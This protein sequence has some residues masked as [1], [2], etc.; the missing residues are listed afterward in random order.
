[1]SPGKVLNYDKLV[2]ATDSIPEEPGFITGYS[3]SGV[4]YIHKSFPKMK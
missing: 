2:F 3:L 1:M 4:E